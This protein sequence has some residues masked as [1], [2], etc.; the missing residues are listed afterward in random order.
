LT[1]RLSEGS[2][3]TLRTSDITINGGRAAANLSIFNS[4]FDDKSQPICPTFI[5]AS[6]WPTTGIPH[7]PFDRN[8]AQL[9]RVALPRSSRSRDCR[10]RSPARDAGE[11]CGRNQTSH[12]P[13]IE[14]GARKQPSP[15]HH[16]AGHGPAGHQFIELALGEAEIACG[17]I[18]REKL[19]HVHRHANGC[20]IYGN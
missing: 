9:R 15:C 12:N 6:S 19:R 8:L 7:D 11:C 16:G 4:D 2:R 3:L 20:R 14:C 1:R 17:L 13:A 5:A 10:Q 18:G